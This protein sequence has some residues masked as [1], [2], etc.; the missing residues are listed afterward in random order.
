MPDIF[1]SEAITPLEMSFDPA[2]MSQGE[3]GL[4]QKFRWRKK[5]YSVVEVLE[6]WKEHGNCR[7]GSGERYLR[8]HGYRIR[9]TDGSVFN[10][11]FQRSSGRGKLSARWWL[12]SIKSQPDQA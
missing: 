11:Y 5:D 2:G 7:H 12:Q 4:P 3:P 8:K 1:V 6:K 10:V 9:T